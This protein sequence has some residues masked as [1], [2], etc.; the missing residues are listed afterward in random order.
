MNENSPYLFQ[1]GV[2]IE[3]LSCGQCATS[4][5]LRAILVLTSFYNIDQPSHEP[6]KFRKPS[7]I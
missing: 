1:Q 3:L 6:G 7:R 2:S 5:L 4:T